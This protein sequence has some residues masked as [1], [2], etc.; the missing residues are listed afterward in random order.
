MNALQNAIKDVKFAIPPEIL[1]IA[2]SEQDRTLNNMIN[3]DDR[4]LSSVIRPR[5][6]VDCNI[7]GGIETRIDLNKCVVNWLSNREFV[8]E[9]PKELSNNRSIITVLS[10]VSNVIYSRTTRYNDTPDIVSV[11]MDLMNN[12][13]SET[14]VQTSR[15]EMLSDNVILISDPSIHIINGI[16][17]CIV[18]NSPNMENIHPRS[19]NAFSKL[20]I[21]AVKS[22]IYN[23][24]VVKLDKGYIYG[25]HELGIIKDIIDNYS[26]AE[27]DYQEYL[28]TV[29]NK[30][31]FIN[32][33]E[34]M[35]RFIRMNIA[36]T[37]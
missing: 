36:N 12:L 35:N 14:V 17:R 19:Y 28:T 8:V 4:M 29:W 18:E 34:K 16:L 26:T 1:V 21:L 5:V 23:T 9:V 24:L 7:V 37:I 30:V 20:V 33:S 22:Y 2:F 13:G 6:L 25:G 11:G 10:L 31:A 15:M 32:D 3:L 27:E